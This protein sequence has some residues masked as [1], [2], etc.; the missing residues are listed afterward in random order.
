MVYYHLF[1]EF[2]LRKQ[3]F[4]GLLRFKNHFVRGQIN[5]NSVIELLTYM[6]NILKQVTT[7]DGSDDSYNYYVNLCRPLVPM[8]GL[9]CPAGAWA[10]RVKKKADQEDGKRVTQV[11]WQY[12]SIVS[13]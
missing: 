1:G 12:L 5:Q 9:N 13:R 8:P 11:K 3:L 4:S 7:E 6:G 10:C 2:L